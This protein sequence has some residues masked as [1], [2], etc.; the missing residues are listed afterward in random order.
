MSVGGQEAQKIGLE[1]AGYIGF[2]KLGVRSQ[3]DA[4]VLR[5]K[6][7]LS[8]AS[9]HRVVEG[10]RAEV[11]ADASE[12]RGAGNAGQIH[13]TKWIE[14]RG[15]YL[16]IQWRRLFFCCAL[17]ARLLFAGILGIVRQNGYR[18]K[19]DTQQHCCKYSHSIPP[20]RFLNWIP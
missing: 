4:R 20:F 8:K 9:G 15:A 5:G 12:L 10:N 2:A 7:L 19:T 11:C 3:A 6:A 1:I 18:H 17:C 14:F 16:E 13:E